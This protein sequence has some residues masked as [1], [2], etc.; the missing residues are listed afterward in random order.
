MCFEKV[1]MLTPVSLHK[2]FISNATFVFA[3]L[4]VS[5]L[6]PRLSPLGNGK[7]KFCTASNRK[8]DRVWE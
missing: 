1:N 7:I 2:V 6:D 4:H 5:S 3:M 8:P